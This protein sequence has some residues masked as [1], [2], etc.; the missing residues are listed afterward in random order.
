MGPENEDNVDQLIRHKFV[1]HSGAV[2]AITSG[3]GL[4]NSQII[5]SSSDCTCKFWSLLR[6]THLRTVVFP[7]PITGLVLSPLESEFFAAGSDGSVYKGTVGIGSRKLKDQQQKL[8]RWSKSHSGSII[9]LVMAN[10][11]TNLVSASEDGGVWVWRADQGQVVLALGTEMGS[12]ISDLIVVNGTSCG[13]EF[14]L[15]LGSKNGGGGIGSGER[16]MTCDFPVKETMEMQSVLA[17]A[18]KDRSRAIDML[19]SAIAVYERL[20]ELILKEAKG[21][22]STKEKDN[23]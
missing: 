16:A 21:T 6:G 3:K 5:T 17:V 2:T 10:N 20:L 13:K 15:R 9:S 7:C 11:G 14:G 4:C 12:S 19:E 1:A 8:L 18:E 22:R 23:R